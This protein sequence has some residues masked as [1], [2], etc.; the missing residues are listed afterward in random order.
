MGARRPDRATRYTA[1]AT[2]LHQH[3][4]SQQAAPQGPKASPFPAA[5]DIRRQLLSHEN[6]DRILG[7]LGPGPPHAA[8]AD[9]STRQ[10]TIER[11]RRDLRVTADKT[12]SP[13]QL[14]IGITLD[15]EDADRL[16]RLVDALARD[17]ATDARARLAQAARQDYRRARDAAERARGKLSQARTQLDEF[18]EGHFA[19]QQAL[20]ERSVGRGLESSHSDGE[21]PV[22][23]PVEPPTP[24]ATVDPRRAELE[25]ELAEL[26]RQRTQL[27]LERTPL[28]PEVQ[29]LDAR[30]ARL[31][32]KLQT[33]PGPVADRHVPP[34]LPE[35]APAEAAPRQPVAA[36]GGPQT[37]NDALP[38]QTAEQYAQAVEA[39]QAHKQA[40]DQ[41]R[42]DFDRLYDLEHHAWA[43]Q[44]KGPSIEQRLSGPRPVGRPVDY[45]PRYVL[46]VVLVA[47][48]V[49]ATGVGLIWS[50]SDVDWPLTTSAQVRKALAVPIV[51]VISAPGPPA[52]TQG[53]PRSRSVGRL[54]MLLGGVAL[55]AACLGLLAAF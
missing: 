15:D 18:L 46:L 48:T 38:D 9:E 21:S 42:Q 19:R 24:S 1:T 47:S 12:S 31:R 30:I 44:V 17:Y 25:T 50:G 52:G 34:S 14:R 40:V 16:V 43:A 33:L 55:I 13:G 28:H 49:A 23:E 37:P 35:E 6:L 5:G 39:F 4:P 26:E 54:A 41:A 22:P 7:Q 10:A 36:E 11:I 2:I 29:S 8:G 32:D 27:L 51:G 53:Q 20:A 3:E 45:W